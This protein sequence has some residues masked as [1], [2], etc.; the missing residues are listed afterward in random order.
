MEGIAIPQKRQRIRC[1]A[2][3]CNDNDGGGD[4]RIAM[5]VDRRIAKKNETK[6]TAKQ[7]KR[8]NEKNPRWESHKRPW[9]TTTN[10]DDKDDDEKRI[11]MV[12]C[13]LTLRDERERELV[14]T[15]ST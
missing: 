14:K 11:A 6:H 15:E 1:D 8:G 3:R 4:K 9:T 12:V 10:D 7:Q 2:I 13:L 5:V